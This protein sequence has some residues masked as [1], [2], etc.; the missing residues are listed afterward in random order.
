M[1]A[2]RPQLDIDALTFAGGS[3][4]NPVAVIAE[5]RSKGGRQASRVG[6]VPVQTWVPIETRK[7]LRITALQLGKDVDD[8]VHELIL[9]FLRAQRG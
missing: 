3:P 5:K 1:S 2:K 4:P 8:L 9:E 6:K 7:R